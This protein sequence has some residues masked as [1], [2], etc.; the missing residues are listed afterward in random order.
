MS[1]L[2]RS[3]PITNDPRLLPRHQNAGCRLVEGLVARSGKSTGDGRFI[4]TYLPELAKVN[5]AV[6]HK[7][8]K[9][10]LEEQR[11]ASVGIGID[12][13]SPI[14]DHEAARKRT[15]ELYRTVRKN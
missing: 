15:L 14:V 5:S 3:A 6:I 10:S 7:R 1:A 2:K 13:P 12:F 11:A 9:M 8:W 4:R